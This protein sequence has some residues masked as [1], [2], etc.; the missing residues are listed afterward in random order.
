MNR[1]EVCAIADLLVY[2]IDANEQARFCGVPHGWQERILRDA[3]HKVRAV[4]KR[5]QYFWRPDRVYDNERYI[6]IQTSLF[7]TNIE[8]TANVIAGLR[9]QPIVDLKSGE[10]IAYEV[11]SRLV[12]DISP[13]T[14]FCQLSAFEHLQ[15]FM[16]Q[17]NSVLSTEL[18]E[19]FHINLPVAVM[20]ESECVITIFLLEHK[21]RIVIE[22]QDPETLATL[23]PEERVSFVDNVEYLISVGWNIWIDD[24][25]GWCFDDIV[26]LNLSFR[27]FKIDYH[28][29]HAARNYSRSLCEMIFDLQKL[30]RMIVVEGI[31]TGEDKEL[32]LKEGIRFGQGYF[33]KEKF[34][35]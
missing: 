1:A 9:L 14:Y 31:E 21:N 23:T 15:I 4:T 10:V 17:Y 5:Q 11:L 29:F 25:N 8:G 12:D 16:W 30:S 24:V 6:D 22:I 20:L 19:K 35:K 26:A 3:L 28:T 13:E 27:G 18:K 34:I 32:A 7:N 2:H 33:W